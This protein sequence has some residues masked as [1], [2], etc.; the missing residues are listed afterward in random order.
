VSA[1]SNDVCISFARSAF[2]IPLLDLVYLPFQLVISVEVI[3]CAGLATKIGSVSS[4][5]E[6]AFS[7]ASLTS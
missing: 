5:K 3:P 7:I 6:P 1:L 4:V 2:G